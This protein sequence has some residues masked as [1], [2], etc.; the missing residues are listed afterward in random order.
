MRPVNN[1]K[2]RLLY[3]KQFF[4]ENTD[5]HH[6]A[7]MSDILHYLELYGIEAERKSIQS[8]IAALEQFGIGLEMNGSTRSLLLI[9]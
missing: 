3:V 2:M 4:E 6:R 9:F 1:G 5:Y 8:D 7:T